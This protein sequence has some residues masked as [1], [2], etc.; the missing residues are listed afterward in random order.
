MNK[1]ELI[2]KAASKSGL[3]QADTQRALDAILGTIKESI[4]QSESVTLVGFGTFL[5]KDKAERKGINP[6]TKAPITIAAK[7]VVAFRPGEPLKKIK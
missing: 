7:K 4:L 5:I 2:E 3:S 1:K 6:A